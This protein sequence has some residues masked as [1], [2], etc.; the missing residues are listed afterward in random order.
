MGAQRL[1]A[2]TGATKV[3]SGVGSGNQHVDD[4][5]KVPAGVADINGRRLLCHYKAAVVR[6]LNLPALLGINS[7]ERLDFVIRCRTGEM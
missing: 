5:I 2:A 6:D 3:R 4:S 1:L 7:L